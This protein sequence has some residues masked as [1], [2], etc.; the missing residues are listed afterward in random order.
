MKE[1][2]RPTV[3]SNMIAPPAGDTVAQDGRPH[4]GPQ[5]ARVAGEAQ[6]PTRCGSSSPA[7]HD[8]ERAGAPRQNLVGLPLPTHQ[9]NALSLGGGEGESAEELCVTQFEDLFLLERTDT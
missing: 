5:A 1:T 3:P 4:D 9:R 7:Q 6:P 2:H 8:P